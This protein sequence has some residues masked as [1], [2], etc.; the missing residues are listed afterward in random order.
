M[1]EERVE[2]R[3]NSVSGISS[4]MG[5]TYSKEALGERLNRRSLEHGESQE[6]E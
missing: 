4:P 6:R 1:A 3:E 2:L 5:S